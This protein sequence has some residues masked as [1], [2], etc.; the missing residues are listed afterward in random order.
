[1][2]RVL[3]VSWLGLM[4][5]SGGDRGPDGVNDGNTEVEFDKDLCDTIPFYDVRGADC[6]TIEENLDR[7]LRD[8]RDCNVDD[9]CLVISG[10]CN[11]HPWIGGC[12]IPVNTCDRRVPPPFPDSP[13]PNGAADLDYF[14]DAYEDSACVFEGSPCGAC[15]SEPQVACIRGECEC[16][17]P[18]A[19]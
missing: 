10:R 3:L 6:Q 4:G 19:C 2:H 7:T 16:L 15:G 13:P 12:W 5:C 14:I 18:N 8:A 9:D 1:M 11:E 17:D